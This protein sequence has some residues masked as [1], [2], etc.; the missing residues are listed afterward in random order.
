MVCS[1]TDHLERL[2][3]TS[4]SVVFCFDGDAAGRRAAW[5]ALGNTLP[6]MR[7]GRQA[8]FVF[9]PEGVSDR[10]GIPDGYA[11]HAAVIRGRLAELAAALDFSGER[12]PAK[13]WPKAQ[14]RVIDGEPRRSALHR[15]AW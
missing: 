5:R 6:V 14:V 9:L 11:R 10:G 15:T 12:T 13:A 3:K 8:S 4:S 1:T 7:D 2:F